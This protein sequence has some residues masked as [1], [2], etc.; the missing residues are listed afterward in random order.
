M[1]AKEKDIPI[2]VLIVDDSP[3]VCDIVADVLS[4]DDG[5]VVVGKA[6]DGEEAVKKVATLRPSIVTMDIEMP[7]MDGFEA[8]ERIMAFSPVPIIVLTSS[9][10]GR[11]KSYVYKALELGAVTVMPKPQ[12]LADLGQRFVDEVKMLS[13]ASVITHLRGK[14]KTRRDEIP[15]EDTLV[16]SEINAVGIVCSTGGPNALRTILGSLPSDLPAGVVIVQHIAE[17]F[18]KELECW[19]REKSAVRIK[20]PAHKDLIEPGT[21]YICPAGRHTIIGEKRSFLLEDSAPVN[22]YR[23]SGD[24]MLASMSQVYGSRAMGVILTGMGSDGAEGLR[25]IKNAGG[26]TIAQD[27]AT[28]L[29]F[30]MPRAAIE[31][32]AVDCIAPIERISEEIVKGLRTCCR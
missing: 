2:K 30:G 12:R 26:L 14:L 3:T 5:I 15:T 11:G 32:G 19:L 7:N 6:L 31:M 18:D 29:I 28:S 24:K 9:M 8:I 21:A 10:W 4:A 25:L 23:P 20:Q 13:K 27:E 17:G 22:C 1:N 16:R